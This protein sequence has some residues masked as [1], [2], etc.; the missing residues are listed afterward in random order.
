M[1]LTLL[2]ANDQ[3]GQHANSWYAA[4]A[5]KIA[6]YKPLQ[7]E[8][9]FDVTIIGAGYSGLSTALH[10]AQRGYKTAVLDAHKVGWGA[11]GRNGGQ[12]ASGQ[13]IDPD[14]MAKLVGN[15]LARQAFQIGVD[16]ATLV[17]ELI[18]IHHID[19][20]YRNGV[21][22]ANHKKRFDRHSQK[23]VETMRDKYGYNRLEYLPPETLKQK[24]NASSYFGGVLDHAAGHLHPLNY[25]LGLAQAATKAG[26]QIFELSEVENIFPGEAPKISTA[27]GSIN[28]DHIVLACNGYLGNLNKQVAEQV[29]PINNFM[30][31]TEPLDDQLSRNIIRDGEAV[32][33]SKFVVNY[34]RLSQD[35]RMLFG[36]G[37]NYGYRFPGD[38]K[39]FVRP[40][41]L[42]TFPQLAGVKID[43]GWG[44]TLAITRHRLPAFSILDGNVLNI[45]GYS[46]S[47]IALATMAEIGRAHV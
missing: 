32:A 34:F 18:E 3:K 26:V 20:A 24:L 29:M 33:D 28:C 35:N 8:H 30:I 44:G 21:I 17:R 2:H 7:G 40:K 25:A 19:C 14:E 38:I 4:S 5:N 42:K 15:T 16:A 12:V 11:S 31:A 41:M 47:G 9:R 6:Q 13:R 36:G 45:S 46:G 43:Y 27:N 10:L 37:E 23:H 39:N 22:E 1:S